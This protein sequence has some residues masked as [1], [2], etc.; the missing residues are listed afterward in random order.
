[1]FPGPASAQGGCRDFGEGRVSK[2]ARDDLEP[3]QFGA[4]ISHEAQGDPHV[5]EVMRAEHE[6]DCESE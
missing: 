2:A 5:S 6:V 1:M 3:G 4:L